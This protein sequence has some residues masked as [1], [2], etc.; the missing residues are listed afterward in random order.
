M[1]QNG[2]RLVETGLLSQ[3]RAY[4]DLEQPAFRRIFNALAFGQSN[5]AD[6]TLQLEGESPPE[7][8]QGDRPR[9]SAK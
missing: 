6:R 9:K 5:D 2:F 4:W 8:R 7:A 3:R 1:R